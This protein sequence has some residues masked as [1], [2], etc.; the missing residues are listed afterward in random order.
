MCQPWNTGNFG[1]VRNSVKGALL[2][3]AVRTNGSFSFC[4]AANILG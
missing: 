2:I 1:F 3:A 4:N